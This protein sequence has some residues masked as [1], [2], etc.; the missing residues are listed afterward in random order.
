MMKNLLILLFCCSVLVFAGDVQSIACVKK[1]S[2]GG[3]PNQAALVTV[4]QPSLLSKLFGRKQI[5]SVIWVTSPKD[6]ST[7]ND[8]IPSKVTDAPNVFGLVTSGVMK[9]VIINKTSYPIV[10]Q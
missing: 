2:Y 6:L 7:R 4:N 10:C 5:T 8:Q 1:L 3:T 9:S